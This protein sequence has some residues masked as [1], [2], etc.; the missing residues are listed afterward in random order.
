[1]SGSVIFASSEPIEAKAGTRQPRVEPRLASGDEAPVDSPV[2][3]LQQEL[4]RFDIAVHVC[5]SSEGKAPG[6]VQLTL[7]LASSVMLWI[8]I[9]QLFSLAW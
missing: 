9:F 6:W 4:G 1:M 5:D 2:H 8:V 7:P 3:A